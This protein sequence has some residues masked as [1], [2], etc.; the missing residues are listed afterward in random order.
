[1]LSF[2][3]DALKSYLIFYKF[4]IGSHVYSYTTGFFKVTKAPYCDVILN[5]KLDEVAWCEGI[6]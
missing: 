3:G 4:T 5:L 6:S 1:M 2:G